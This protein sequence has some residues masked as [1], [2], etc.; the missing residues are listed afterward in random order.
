MENMDAWD[1]ALLVVAAFVAV[2][3]LVRLMTRRHRQVLDEFRREI[4][5]HKKKAAPPPEQPRSRRSA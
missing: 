2:M 1:V 5:Q 3:A 4:E